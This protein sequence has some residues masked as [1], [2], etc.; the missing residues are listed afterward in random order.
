MKY[1]LSFYVMAVPRGIFEFVFGNL[2]ARIMY[3]RKNI[4]GKYFR[5]KRKGFLNLGWG[6]TLSDAIS[7][8]FLGINRGVPFV[9]SPR[10]HINNGE[11]IFFDVDD[12]LIFQGQGK[13]FQAADASITIGKGCYIADNVGLITTNHDIYNLLE[14]QEGKPII[15]GNGCW[16][17]MNSCILPGVHLGDHTIVGAGSIVTKSFP[18]GYCVIVGNPAKKIKELNKLDF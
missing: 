1:S 2:F 16:L 6:W 18:E 13:Y 12:L 17:G 4:G 8:V 3:K 7:R 9:V 11:N 15:L 5:G 10:N 14:H